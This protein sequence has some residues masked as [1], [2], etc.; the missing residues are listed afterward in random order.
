[1][2]HP[3]NDPSVTGRLRNA[4]SLVLGALAGLALIVMMLFTAADITLRAFG[5]PVA[6]SFEVI[7]W[8]SAAAMA[9][10]L[11]YAQAHKSHVA[12]TLFSDRLRG[13]MAAL[14]EC[15]NGLLALAAFGTAAYY[16][17]RYGNTLQS[18]GSLSETLRV[19]VYPWVYIVAVGCSGLVLVLLLDWIDSVVRLVAGRARPT[20]AG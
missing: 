20:T 18:S 4:L 11:G 17:F 8:L 1:M 7:G 12:M 5:R 6:G 10:A 3:M 14:A 19:V 13:R 2:T 15:V 9:L 16:L